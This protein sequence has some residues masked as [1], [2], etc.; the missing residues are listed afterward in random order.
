MY[1]N[2]AQEI[3]ISQLVK[4]FLVSKQ[5]GESSLEF[6]MSETKPLVATRSFDSEC[7]MFGRMSKKDREAAHR[8]N[9]EK[10]VVSNLSKNVYSRDDASEVY[11]FLYIGNLASRNTKFLT[12]K[13][14]VLIINGKPLSSSSLSKSFAK[15]ALMQTNYQL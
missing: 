10:A 11:P 1:P 9:Q 14:I 15:C 12:E 8:R 7:K 3:V 5:R 6:T 4:D 13:D 2:I